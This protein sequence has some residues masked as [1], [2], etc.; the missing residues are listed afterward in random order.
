MN[1]PS[2]VLVATDL[3]APAHYAVERAIDLAEQACAGGIA[4]RFIG[5]QR[6][7]VKLLPNF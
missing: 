5:R 4:M 1:L 6:P 3:S 2:R 7:S